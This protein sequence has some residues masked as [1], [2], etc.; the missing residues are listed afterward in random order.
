MAWRTGHPIKKS[1]Q[2]QPPSENRKRTRNQSFGILIRNPGSQELGPENLSLNSRVGRVILNPP[3]RPRACPRREAQYR[4]RV[5]DNAP[6]PSV[7]P[8]WV[9]CFPIFDASV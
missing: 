8:R 5:K 6:Y 3:T 1:G 2:T 9:G 7:L 4:R